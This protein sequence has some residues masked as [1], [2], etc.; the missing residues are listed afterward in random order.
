V[1]LSGFACKICSQR[2]LE[3]ISS[4]PDLHRVSSDCKTVPAGGRL[5][6][7]M[8][9]GAVQ[10]PADAAWERDAAAIYE[11]YQPYFQSGGVEQA[12]FDPAKGIPRR[13]SAAI[14]DRLSET[15]KLGP[16]GSVLDVGCGNGVLLTAFSEIRPQWKLFG[17]ELSEL[18]LPKL[19][20][21]PG[22]E[23]LF[24]GA[25]TAIPGQFDVITMMHSLEHFPEPLSG[26]SDLKPKI[27][28]KG[29]LFVEIPNG[30]ATPFD[31][32]IADHA[33]HFSRHDLAR[34][35]ARA[36]M[37]ASVIANDW[38]TKELSVVVH[39]DGPIVE[40]PPPRSPEAVLKRVKAQVAWLQ[41]MI[42]SAN[43]AS[44][45]GRF[46]I[47]GTSIAAMWLFGE[48]GDRV[49]FF[50][51]EDPSRKQAKLFDRPILTPAETPKD[52]T[53]YVALIPEVA[54]AV[55]GRLGRSDVHFEVPP[56][57]A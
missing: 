41:A 42:D 38:I 6:V 31:L 28:D 17:H 55:A 23:K 25:L 13:R 1:K 19:K 10:K 36:G 52:A 44:K 43:A 18:N 29:C 56:P 45:K 11:N 2:E 34:L 22:F 54:R 48:V 39:R 53:V 4:F 20:T 30:E 35:I 49:D 37:G 40:L 24:T 21:I 8:A 27:A 26:L 14:L 5:A 47:F 32:L 46:G 3:E 12:V 16:S 33:S 51:D 15:R 9:C 7:C 57:V 50:I